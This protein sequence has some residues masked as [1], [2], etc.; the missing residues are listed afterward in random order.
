MGWYYGFSAAGD[1]LEIE[2][3]KKELHEF[4]GRVELLESEPDKLSVRTSL[5]G[6]LLDGWEP[7]EDMIAQFPALVFAD[8]TLFTTSMRAHEWTFVG[9]S[10]VTTWQHSYSEE[11]AEQEWAIEAYNH[12]A[13]DMVDLIHK[14]GE[15]RHRMPPDEVAQLEAR[16]AAYNKSLREAAEHQ[17]SDEAHWD[18]VDIDELK[19]HVMETLKKL[20][21]ESLS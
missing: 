13:P 1:P 18:D 19:N 11:I 12:A 8:G 17:A 3:L 15:N 5:G 21:A 16:I 4:W 2:R 6:M 20:T 9:H 7:V 10:G 14:L